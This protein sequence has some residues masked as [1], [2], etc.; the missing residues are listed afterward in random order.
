MGFVAPKEN[1]VT[2]LGRREN[3]MGLMDSFFS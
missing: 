3:S 1:P 2:S